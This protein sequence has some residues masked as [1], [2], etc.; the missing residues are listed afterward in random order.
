MS[1][2]AASSFSIMKRVRI[3][4]TFRCTAGKSESRQ[5][6]GGN[7]RDYAYDRLSAFIAFFGCDQFP[8]L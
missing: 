6:V 3:S 1:I 2:S 8:E 4:E 7:G 5:D